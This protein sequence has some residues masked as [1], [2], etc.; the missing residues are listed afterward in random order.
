M[1]KRIAVRET[2][3]G[4]RGVLDT[5]VVLR[6]A[7]PVMDITQVERLAHRTALAGELV[8]LREGAVV[9]APVDLLAR[10]SAQTRSQLDG[11]QRVGLDHERRRHLRLEG[12]FDAQRLVHDAHRSALS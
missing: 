8:R 2:S 9:D 12:R 4:L 10:D 5:A 1:L 6:V 3:C 7:Y 11:D